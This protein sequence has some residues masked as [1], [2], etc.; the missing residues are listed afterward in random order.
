MP[1]FYRS[2]VDVLKEIS[3]RSREKRL[4][5]NLSQKTLSEKSGVSYGTLKKFE[6]T[7]KISIESLLKIAIVLDS[8]DDFDYLFAKDNLP[9][10]IDELFKNKNSRKRGRK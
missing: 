1:L 2:V 3:I 8:L 7:G 5:M 4:S 6:S 9:D 10:S